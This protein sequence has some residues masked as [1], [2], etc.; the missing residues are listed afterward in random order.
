ML[1]RPPRRGYDR[2]RKICSV[3]ATWLGD[4]VL[5]ILVAVA[6]IQ[7]ALDNGNGGDE[8]RIDQY[9]Y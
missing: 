1:G 7:I 4:V 9:M 5:I 6:V 2:G 3:I 8:A